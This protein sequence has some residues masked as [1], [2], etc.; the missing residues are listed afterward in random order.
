[1]PGG[2]ADSEPGIPGAAPRGGIA[3]RGA[4]CDR[5]RVTGRLTV[6]S[7]ACSQALVHGHTSDTR[8]DGAGRRQCVPL[9]P[10][11]PAPQGPR[12]P[13]LRRCSCA[14][15]V[16]L[17]PPGRDPELKCCY[18][19]LRGMSFLLSS[20]STP[21]ASM[22]QSKGLGAG[23]PGGG[24]RGGGPVMC[25]PERRRILPSPC[26]QVVETLGQGSSKTRNQ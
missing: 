14:L 1:M 17:Q 5:P 26:R 19:A 25:H 18:T 6:T 20:A 10:P 16:P 7:G 24:G 21:P 13:A 15:Q 8:G 4:L 9:P 22:E 3:V 2:T 11:T 23:A 12:S